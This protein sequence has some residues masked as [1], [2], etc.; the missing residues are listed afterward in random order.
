MFLY[1]Y[2]SCDCHIRCILWFI[3]IQTSK[4]NH[5]TLKT[6]KETFH[7]HFSHKQTYKKICFEIAKFT[8][9]PDPL[10]ELSGSNDE[11][12]LFVYQIIRV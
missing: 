7:V 12:F 3:M 5:Q 1:F 2:V 8:L 6:F 9:N 4:H 11:W 10:C